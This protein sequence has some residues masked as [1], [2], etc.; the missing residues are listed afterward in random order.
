[1]YLISMTYSKMLSKQ[2]CLQSVL[3]CVYVFD[4]C[5]VDFCAVTLMIS[6]SQNSWERDNKV[7]KSLF[8]G[9]YNERHDTTSLIFFVFG[10]SKL[11]TISACFVL[12]QQDCC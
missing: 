8:K 7:D 3:F 4:D 6:A 11:K 1:M 5:L 10:F 9:E 2:F 12:H